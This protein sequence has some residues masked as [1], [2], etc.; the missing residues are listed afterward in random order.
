MKIFYIPL[1]L[2]CL[3]QNAQ[4]QQTPM[5]LN[6]TLQITHTE[7][8]K[9]SHSTT[10]TWNLKDKALFYGQSFGGRLSSKKPI[11][12][13][14]SLST[15]QIAEIEK[16]LSDK[17]LY[18]NIPSPKYS[19]FHVPYSAIHVRLNIQKEEESFEIDLYDLA[20]EIPKNTDYQSIEALTRLLKKYLP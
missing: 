14:N 4:S 8:S 13:N 20:S 10:E 1:V 2:L 16:L 17:D 18:K 9:D 15:S 3:F 11:R 6:I 7:K 19:E 5:K 12:K